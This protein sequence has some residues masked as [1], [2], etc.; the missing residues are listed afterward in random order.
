[1]IWKWIVKCWRWSYRTN[2]IVGG[3]SNWV[4]YLGGG[5]MSYWNSQKVTQISMKLIYCSFAMF[6]YW[7]ERCAQCWRWS[8]TANSILSGIVDWGFYWGWRSMSYWNSQKVRQ[9]SRKL[10]CCSLSMIILIWVYDLKMDRTVLKMIIQGWFYSWW[11][12]NLMLLLG[13]RKPVILKF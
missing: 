1:M 5:S 6:I 3:I 12:L 7:Y 8:C 13:S 11:F 9:M 4:F 10:L 2:Y